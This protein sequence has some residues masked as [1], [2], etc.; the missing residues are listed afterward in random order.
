ME[1][2]DYT[3]PACAPGNAGLG[4]ERRNKIL[5][6]DGR[7]KGSQDGADS[8][9]HGQCSEAEDAGSWDGCGDFEALQC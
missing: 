4:R 5:P 1:Q 8:G 2:S 9:H 6:P 7:E 3:I